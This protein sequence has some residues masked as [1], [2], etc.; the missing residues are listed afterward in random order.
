MGSG[1]LPTRAR[2]GSAPAGRLAGLGASHLGNLDKSWISSYGLQIGTARRSKSGT[3]SARPRR[4]QITTSESSRK[5]AIGRARLSRVLSVFPRAPDRLDLSRRILAALAAP[6]ARR[7]F[8]RL[9]LLQLRKPRPYSILDESTS[10]PRGDEVPHFVQKGVVENYI[11]ACHSGASIYTQQG[12]LV[13]TGCQSYRRP[14][15]PC[16]CEQIKGLVPVQTS[17]PPRA[18]TSSPP[19]KRKRF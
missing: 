10:L 12:T 1:S 17:P 11:H 8:G 4:C 19:R 13:R 9:D 16:Y 2:P 5:S 7:G 6:C 14:S 18:S 15:T 3:T